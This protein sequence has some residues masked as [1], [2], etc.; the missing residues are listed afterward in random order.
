MPANFDIYALPIFEFYLYQVTKEPCL[1]DAACEW[2]SS[3]Q[4]PLHHR[5]QF[6]PAMHVPT[7]PEL[8]RLQSFAFKYFC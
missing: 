2:P 4:I 3:G 7:N 1:K 6:K 5:Q 8:F